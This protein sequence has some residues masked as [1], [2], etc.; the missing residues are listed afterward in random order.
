M[1]NHEFKRLNR[2]QLIEI[3]YQLQL[4]QDELTKEN[5]NLKMSLEDK[6]LRISEAGS[7]AEAALKINNC[8]ESAQ[9]AAQQYLN[10]IKL[11]HAEAENVL[12]DA[13][14]QAN[15]ILANAKSKPSQNEISIESILKEYKQN[16]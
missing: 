6:R 8:F 13:K 9:N 1:T 10:E 16:K 5:L 15:E 12:A 4:K 3:I 14:K 11:M 2:A 7:I